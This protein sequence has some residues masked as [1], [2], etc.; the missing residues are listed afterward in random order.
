[1]FLQPGYCSTVQQGVA[2][3]TCWGDLDARINAHAMQQFPSCSSPLSMPS[4]T[5]PVLAGHA[6]PS[7]QPRPLPLYSTKQNR[8][9]SLCV[10]REPARVPGFEFDLGFHTSR[11]PLCGRML[12]YR[13][14][15]L[16]FSLPE[17]RDVWLGA[18]SLLP[19]S[20]VRRRESSPAL[21]RPDIMVHAAA[22]QFHLVHIVQ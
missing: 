15:F 14:S 11:P 22:A 1:M 16:K 21:V 20:S 19:P 4:F 3:H 12:Q 5:H 9:H 6:F 2:E 7:R 18:G 13:G 8:R 17:G 10:A